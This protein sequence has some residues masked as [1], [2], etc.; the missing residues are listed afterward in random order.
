MLRKL[1][2]KALSA[3]VALAV[4]GSANAQIALDELFFTAFDF[5]SQTSFTLDL[6]IPFNN[7]Q[8]ATQGFAAL[9]LDTLSS[10]SSFLSGVTGVV[11]WTIAASTGS[12]NRVLAAGAPSPIP[13]NTGSFL[14][15]YNVRVSTIRNNTNSIGNSDAGVVAGPATFTGG[16]VGANGNWSGTMPW[17]TTRGI[18][19]TSSIVTYQIA[20]ATNPGV[21]R[22]SATLTSGNVLSVTPVP[23]PGTYALMLAGLFAVG[24][25]ARRRMGK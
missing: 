14:N 3:A 6:N 20:G 23:E 25:I 8:N 24:A 12:P 4:T 16:S 18:G 21:L 17:D 19:A 15:G 11:Q 1:R 2:I 10:W 5:G 22:G 13:N 9:D 7:F